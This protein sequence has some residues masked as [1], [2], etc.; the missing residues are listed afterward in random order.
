METV[1]INNDKS[2]VYIQT[3]SYATSKEGVN[4]AIKDEGACSSILHIKIYYE[5]CPSS[6]TF[7]THFPRTVSGEELNAVKKVTGKC[8]QNATVANSSF[9]NPVSLCKADGSWQ[10]LT[11]ECQCVPGFIS[12][13]NTNTCARKIFYL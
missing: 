3:I 8:S 9:K 10:M 7:L 1:A 5:V 13:K 6:T 11:S 12:S 4:F 2:Q